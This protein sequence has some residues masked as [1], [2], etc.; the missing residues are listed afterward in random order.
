MWVFLLQFRLCLL[1][2]V[3]RSADGKQKAFLAAEM[4]TLYLCLPLYICGGLIAVY[5]NSRGNKVDEAT[6]YAYS[7]SY[8]HACLFKPHLLNIFQ[9][10]TE[11]ALSRFF[12]LGNTFVRLLPHAYDLYRAHFY[13]EDFDGSYMYAEPGGDYFS[14]AWDVIIPLVTLLFAAV[15]YL[16]QRFGGRCFMPKRLKE[17]EGYEKVPVA[18]DHA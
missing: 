8:Q 9:N 6:G 10:S 15:I 18:S 7:S 5:V 3:S 14:T 12:Y 11:N 1:C 2:G 16:Q 4:R 13:V 17:P